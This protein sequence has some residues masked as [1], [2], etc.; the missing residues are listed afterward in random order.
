VK[1]TERGDSNMSQNDRRSFLVL[2]HQKVGMYGITIEEERC[3]C[4]SG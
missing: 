4:I 1:R 2:Y 3:R